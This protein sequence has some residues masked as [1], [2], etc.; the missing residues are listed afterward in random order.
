MLMEY[1]TD[2]Q[3]KEILQNYITRNDQWVHE[4]FQKALANTDID[5]ETI[6]KEQIENLIDATF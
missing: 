4:Y 2:L 6:T 5:V 1:L 3:V